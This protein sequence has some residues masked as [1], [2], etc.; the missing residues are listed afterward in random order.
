MVPLNKE[1][2]S[3]IDEILIPFLQQSPD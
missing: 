3:G 1:N 2:P